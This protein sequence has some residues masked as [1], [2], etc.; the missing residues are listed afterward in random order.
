MRGRDI[1]IRAV[2]A[3]LA[4]LLAASCTSGSPHAVRPS[5]EPPPPGS[6]IAFT[7]DTAVSPLVA[8]DVRRGTVRAVGGSVRTPITSTGVTS[9][10][11]L[12]AVVVA[13]SGDAS[14]VRVASSG[15]ATTVGPVLGGAPDIVSRSVGV[16]GDRAMVA[17]CSRVWV[18][19]TATA[20][21]WRAVAYGCWAALSPDGTRVAYSPDGIHVLERRLDGRRPT[22]L[23]DVPDIDL[24]TRAPTRLI[25][26]PA[27]GPAGIAFTVV[28]GDQAA[29]YLDPL[30]PVGLVRLWQ[31]PLLK[32]VRPPILAWQPG[33]RLLGVMDDLATGGVIR[34]FDAD[35]RTDRVVALDPLGFS[36]LVWSPDGSALATLT[37]S[38]SLLVVD[39]AGGWR[40]RVRTTWTGMLGWVA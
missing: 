36:G 19:D 24:G 39:T 25:G 14:V 17:D 10:G 30:R 15:D 11:T 27:W 12:T 1:A 16:V 21:R 7:R 37:S 13:S 4:V 22:L 2:P 32:T 40:A 33:G 8:F 34:V 29:T 6:I 26:Q 28:S 35:A 5:A 18:L 31:E 23:F 9:D 20:S 38:S 3:G